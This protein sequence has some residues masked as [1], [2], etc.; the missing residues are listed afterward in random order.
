MNPEFLPIHTSDEEE[1]KYFKENP[2]LKEVIEGI[3]EELLVSNRALDK[4]SEQIDIKVAKLEGKAI[5]KENSI[6]QSIEQ[7]KEHIEKIENEL[8]NVYGHDENNLDQKLTFAE[9]KDNPLDRSFI[10]RYNKIHY[11]RSQLL[12]SNKKLKDKILLNKHPLEN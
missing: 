1:K 9:R 7:N 2:H 3:K 8:I 10:E 5:L 4:E 11:E 6:E 12:D